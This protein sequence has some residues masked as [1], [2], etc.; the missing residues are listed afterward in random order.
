MSSP[1]EIHLLGEFRLLV[2]GEPVLALDTPLRQRLLAYLLLNR[3]TPQLRQ[4]I[5]FAFWPDSSERQ[6]FTNLR[7]LLFQLRKVLPSIDAFLVADHSTIGW[8]TDAAYWLDVAALEAALNDLEQGRGELVARSQE[9]VRL[10]RGELLPNCYDDWLLPLRRALHE[11]VVTRLEQAVAALTAQREVQI[12][13]RCAEHL[14]RLD[15]LH[16]TPYRH[17][18]EL[19]ALTHDRAGALRVYHECARV[20]DQELGV[21]PSGETQALYH[22][23]LNMDTL[24]VVHQPAPQALQIQLVGRQAEWQALQQ[25]WQRTAQQGTHYVMIWGEAGIGK[26]R[27]VEELLHWAHL[28]PGSVAYTSAYAAEGALA[29]APVADWLRS[30]ALYEAIGRLDAVWRTEL[31]RLVPS[32]LTED[33]ALSPP[34]PLSEDWQRQRFHEAMARAVLAAPKPR[35]LVIDDVQWC[36]R[37]TLA[38]L[39]YLLRFEPSAPLL[40]VG[41][42]RSEAVDADHPL[43]EIVRQLQRARQVTE[44]ELGSLDAAE[45]TALAQQLTDADMGDWG[46]RIYRETEGNP[47]FVVETVRAGLDKSTQAIGDLPAT[48]QAVIAT[49]LAQL[50]TPARELAQLAATVGRAFGVE[51]LLATG[52]LDEAALVQSLDELWQRRLVREAQDGYDFSHDKIREVAYGEI[53]LARRRLYHRSV[54]LALEQLRPDRE[55]FHAGE[56]AVHFEQAGERA[57]AVH[58]FR[59]AGNH[60]AAQF[61]NDEAV[62]YFMRG[63]NL[64]D[65]DDLATQYDLMIQLHDVYLRLGQAVEQEKQLDALR[66]LAVKLDAAENTSLHQ[67]EVGV[68]YADLYNRIGKLSAGERECEAALALAKDIGAVAVEATGYFCWGRLAW[69]QGAMHVARTRYSRAV[70]LARDA[71]QD[72]LEAEILEMLAAT[73]MFSGMHAEMLLDHLTRCH[74]IYTR[75]GDVNGQASILNKFGYLP[76]AQATGEFDVAVTAY[77]QSIALCRQMGARPLESNVL[78]NLGLLYAQM[79]NYQVALEYLND[80]LDYSRETASRLRLAAT[81]AYRGFAWRNIGHYQQAKDDLDEALSVAQEIRNLQWGNRAQSELGLTHL[82]LGEVDAAIT[83][84]QHAVQNAQTLTDPRLEAA[85]WMAMG[86][87]HAATGAWEEAG[88]AYQQ[89]YTLHSKMEQPGYTLMAQAG[90]AAAAWHSGDQAARAAVE[91]ILGGLAQRTLEKTDDSLRLYLTCH[92]I[93][94]ADKDPRAQTMCEATKTNLAVR[95]A[96]LT[97]A[98]CIHFWSVPLHREA[99]S[100]TGMRIG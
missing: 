20:L 40:V 29:Y 4:Q 49:R 62:A 34:L 42:V 1:L 44:L 61:A 28:R 74:A 25:A 85:G 73:G 56:I 2:D 87:I 27:L 8:R 12:A 37:E 75:V 35:L 10:Y 84:V 15:P 92:T 63:L 17:L 7:K 50:S 93:L 97:E 94:T 71:G 41:T 78:S 18:M 90:V 58:Y 46:E 24:P 91:A 83:H 96:T 26:T 39:R 6:A 68:R 43:H 64:V 66:Q 30:P 98:Q 19:H 67:A 3:L 22:H 54:A 38:W 89:A 77:Q 60:A 5:A 23:L 45:T 95:A 9:V 11:R 13:M 99:A 51:V 100:V 72:R 47:L 57:K 82:A 14:I 31:A 36:D 33:P 80:A 21:P 52:N 76:M 88:Q 48:V 32:L 65:A 55:T 70:E 86:H 79:G 69:T 81:L 59:A 16:E 53:S